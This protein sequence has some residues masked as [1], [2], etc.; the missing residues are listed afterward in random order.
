MPREKARRK[1][2]EEIDAYYRKHYTRGAEYLPKRKKSGRGV[3]NNVWL[4]AARELR[5]SQRESG[6]TVFGKIAE[7]VPEWMR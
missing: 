5:Q 2:Q 1:I 3:V 7:Y 6:K 4:K